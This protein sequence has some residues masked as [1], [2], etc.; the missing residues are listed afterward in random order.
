MSVLRIKG[1]KRYRVKGRWY[2]YH[3][4][5]GTRLKFEFGTAE[6]VE[7]LANLES[8]LRKAEALPGTLGKLFAS[9]KA[10]SAYADLASTTKQ[11][12]LRMMNLLRPLDEMPLIEL[13]PQF[14]AGLRDRI[15][16]KHGRRQANYVMAVVSVACEHGKEHGIVR[17]NPVKGVKRVRR[18]RSAPAANRPWTVEEC[19][20]VLTELPYQLR[21]PVALAMFTGLR[22]GDVLALKKSAIR[23]GRIWRKTNKTGQEVSIPIHPDL[24]HILAVSPH[25]NAITIAATTSATPWTESGFNSSFIKAMAALKKV[26]KIGQGLTFHGLRHTVGTLLIEAGY[27]I[28]TVRRWLGQKTL[29]MAIHYS[30]SADTSEKMREVVGRL[31]PLG[32][33]TRT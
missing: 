30:H 19:R 21:V 24:A 31:D 32:S 13:T 8:K 15:S 18:S 14:I 23:D 6:F 25:H 20:T 22:K 2:A 3:R 17:D 26:G 7:E 27:D 28:D 10:S 5:S 9:Y 29:A 1:L 12:Y 16:E 11:G 4:K 33:K